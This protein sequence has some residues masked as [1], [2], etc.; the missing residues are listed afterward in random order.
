MLILIT[1]KKF[2]LNGYMRNNGQYKKM[3]KKQA[4]IHY[5]K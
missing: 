1:F 2:L 4:F 5:N 3:I